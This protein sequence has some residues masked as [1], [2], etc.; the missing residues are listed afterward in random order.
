[1]WRAGRGAGSRRGAARGVR[2]TQGRQG[3]LGPAGSQRWCHGLRNS[4][5][6]RGGGR[7]TSVRP[8]SWLC[9]QTFVGF[10]MV[11]QIEPRTRAR[12]PV[13]PPSPTLAGRTGRWLGRSPS[14]LEGRLQLLE[15]R[16]PLLHLLCLLLP[17][18]LLSLDLFLE[19]AGHVDGLHL[20]GSGGEVPQRKRGPCASMWAFPAA[21]LTSSSPG[22]GTLFS[23]RSL[24]FSI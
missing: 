7:A 11:P 5:R 13:C 1:M 22:T 3:G 8:L 15:G 6:E 21:P 10:S 20:G 24:S 14:L 12:L 2:E 9:S 23:S 17:L 19:A 4:S 16:F 18:L